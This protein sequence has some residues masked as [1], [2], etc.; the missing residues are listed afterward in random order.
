MSTFFS[1][2]IVRPSVLVNNDGH[3]FIPDLVLDVR[4]QDLRNEDRK[5]EEHEDENE[6][7]DHQ[8]FEMTNEK[9][10]E[11]TT[12]RRTGGSDTRRAG[13]AERVRA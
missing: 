9:I 1:V 6:D 3:T 11:A 13:E 8:T 12:V 4:D 7:D 2:L 10:N 5:V